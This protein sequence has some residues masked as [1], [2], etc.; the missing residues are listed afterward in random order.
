MRQIINF[1]ISICLVSTTYS[2]TKDIFN[3]T[4]LIHPD[5]IVLPSPCNLLSLNIAADALGIIEDNISQKFTRGLGDSYSLSCFYKWEE[6]TTPN[7][8]M[9]LQVIKNGYPENSDF[10]SKSFQ[11]KFTQGEFVQHLDRKILYKKHKIGKLEIAY[12]P[13]T[14]AAFWHIGDNYMF[15]LIFN[16]NTLNEDKFLKI[17]NQ[18]VPEVN[19]NMLAHLLK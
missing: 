10:I 19:K 8:G 9:L 12:N 16:L 6:P 18:V 14:Y 5:S 1:F 4:K 3:F 17:I 2:Q 11:S 7:A 15:H 13:E